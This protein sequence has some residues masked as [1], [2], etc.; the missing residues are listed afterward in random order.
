MKKKSL[1][2]ALALAICL[3]LTVPVFAEERPM[4][5]EE[6]TK[7]ISITADIGELAMD[8]LNVEKA[9]TKVDYEYDEETWLSLIHI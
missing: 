6:G 7:N 1:S 9:W 5:V 3:S 8:D 4:S 2:L